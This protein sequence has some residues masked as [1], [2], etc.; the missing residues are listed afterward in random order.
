MSRQEVLNW[1]VQQAKLCLGP[2]LLPHNTL[3]LL[4]Y[5]CTAGQQLKTLLASLTLQRCLQSG[6]HRFRPEQQAAGVHIC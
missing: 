2:Q 6:A 3:K 4:Y 5:L 1:P